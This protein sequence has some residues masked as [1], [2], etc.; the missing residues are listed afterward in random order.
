LLLKRM[1]DAVLMVQ[2]A[3]EKKLYN[4]QDVAR[5]IIAQRRNTLENAMLNYGLLRGRKPSNEEIRQ[6][7]MATRER[8]RQAGIVNARHI[9]CK[10]KAKADE[11]YRRL[12][13]GGKRNDWM[14]VMVDLSVNQDSK[15]MDGSVGW[16]NQGGVIPFIHG[17]E[18]FTNEVY[19]FEKGLHAPFLIADRWHVVEVLGR[20]NERP[21]SF[22]EAKD[23]V[24]LAMMPGWQDAII[25]GYL[26]E[27]RKKHTVEMFGEFAPGQGLS[28]D[29]LFSRALAV[30]EPQRKIELLNLLYT[31]YPESDRAD[32][33]LFL[34]ANVA[35]DS[36]QDARVAQMYLGIL[37]EEYPD[38]DLTEDATF[39]QENLFNPAVLNP[40]SM[41][42]LRKKDKQGG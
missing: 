1:I 5:T 15:D 29:E 11:A 13:E 8:Y 26:R 32:D 4:D 18:K 23:Q 38:S 37:L 27:S 21:M 7:F 9:E 42:D 41:E 36:W 20:E 40:K 34:A 22:A 25:K 24:E 39:L 12:I 28:P 16:F 17:S 33:A 2:G 31:D 35:L 3:V 14:N 30:V 19:G 10:T 6:N